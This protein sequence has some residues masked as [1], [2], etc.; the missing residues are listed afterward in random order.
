MGAGGA[1]IGVAFGVSTLPVALGKLGSAAS[2]GGARGS[3]VDVDVLEPSFGLFQKLV[4]LDAR[5]L[6]GG[7]PC[8]GFK[9]GLGFNV[10]ASL[11][12]T[13]EVD[14]SISSSVSSASIRLSSSGNSV[15]DPLIAM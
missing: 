10:E 6:L 2:F 3:V 1:D 12:P 8:A 15:C 14:T 9:P 4:E 11:L 7:K 13:I 5:G